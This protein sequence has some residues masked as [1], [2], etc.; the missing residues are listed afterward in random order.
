MKAVPYIDTSALA[1]WYV[2]EPR[3]DD[4]EA[5][6]QQ[7][8]RADI[9]RLTVVEF[10]CL[11]ARRQRALEVTPRQARRVFAAFEED[12]RDGFLFV[13]PLE[14]RHAVSALALIQRLER[15]PLRTLDALHLAV[16]LDLKSPKVATADRVLTAAAQELGMEVVR[17]D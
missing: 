8:A 7:Q 12:V 16:A 11:L 14:D 15:H 17:F 3:S 4:F 9:S 13:H 1:K 5:F 10:R 2:N 6:L